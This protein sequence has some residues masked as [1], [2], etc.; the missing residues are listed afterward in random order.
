MLKSDFAKFILFCFASLHLIP[1]EA[2][3]IGKALGGAALVA[4]AKAAANV[5]VDEK[6]RPHDAVAADCTKGKFVNAPVMRKIDESKDRAGQINVKKVFDIADPHR[7]LVFVALDGTSN[8]GETFTPADY[9][10]WPTPRYS[11]DKCLNQVRKKRA[12]DGNL[13]VVNIPTNV[14]LLAYSVAT[15]GNYPKVA[16]IYLKGV[17]TDPNRNLGASSNNLYDSVAGRSLIAQVVVAYERIEEFVRT[18]KQA[19]PEATFVFVTTGF[20]RGAAAV[21]IFHNKLLYEG[22]RR[23]SS[24]YF[25]EPG[26][27]EIGASVLFDTVT[28]QFL[29]ERSTD[30]ALEVEQHLYFIPPT[31]TQVLH[32]TA[33]NE[34]RTFFPLT[35]AVGANVAEISIP[36]AHSDI[37]GSYTP[38]GISAVTLEIAR[39]Y[40][41]AAGVPLQ[42]LANEY[43]PNPRKYILHDS[44]WYPTMP[45]D[46]QLKR[47][48]EIKY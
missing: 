29:L 24:T 10:P 11:P 17:G 28:S 36:G 15:S 39:S 21:R 31:L 2:S 19:D 9:G 6:F 32:L 38:D 33:A 27:A 22:V 44:R 12:S 16:A 42:A 8:H 4:G 5:Y 34:Y 20:S 47:S 23:D 1:A 40:L 18:T 35:R 30:G 3:L 43:K 13:V 46:E 25:I 45:F 41:T 26:K 14:R 37:G 7:Y 48:R